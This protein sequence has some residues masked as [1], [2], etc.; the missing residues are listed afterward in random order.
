MA[1]AAA[2]NATLRA[3]VEALE[4]A[5]EAERALVAEALATAQEALAMAGRARPKRGEAGVQVRF[6][7]GRGRQRMR[8]ELEASERRENCKRECEGV[9]C[10]QVCDTEPFSHFRDKDGWSEVLT[11]P[12]RPQRTI[13]T[14]ESCIQFA[15]PFP[16]P[17]KR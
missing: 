10:A 12:D 16:L 11:T 1:A 8:R 15:Y 9:C 5:T 4:G 3:A 7:A 14:E 17:T 13:F 2:R 6:P